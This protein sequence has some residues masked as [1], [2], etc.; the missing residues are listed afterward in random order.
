MGGQSRCQGKMG[1]NSMRIIGMIVAVL[2]FCATGCSYN[3]TGSM[4]KPN[5]NFTKPM[6]LAVVKFKNAEQPAV[7][8]E[9][10]D[11]IAMA[12]FR[13]G[14]DIVEINQIINAP[15]QDKIYSA[16]LTAEVKTKLKNY[17]ITAV[18]L[19]SINEY[20][21]IVDSSYLT[22][23]LT[24]YEDRTCR[25]SF[26]A[27]MIDL[28]SGEILWGLSSSDAKAGDMLQADCVLRTM[29]RSLD[30]EIPL[31]LS[32]QQVVNTQ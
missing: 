29:M 22:S 26:S 31:D 18:I 23:T 4:Y 5:V 11:M 16:G 13:K 14:F 24:G 28:A 19:G 9:A 21:C 7:G 6:K 27:T 15:E 3:A 17:G 20:Y 2:V 10:A 12:F 1:D 32:R 30:K 25:V 8:Q